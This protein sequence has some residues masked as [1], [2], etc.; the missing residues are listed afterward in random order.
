MPFDTPLSPQEE[1][2]F[3]QWFSKNKQSGAT[4]PQDTGHD[5]DLRGAFKAGVKPGAD[6]HWPD[7]FKKPNHPTFSDESIYSSLTGTKPGHWNG[8]NLI[9]FGAPMPQAPDYMQPNQHSGM[10]YSQQ[11]NPFWKALEGVVNG[12]RG[13]QF[14]SNQRPWGMHEP[15]VM[16]GAGVEQGLRGA[17][18][19]MSDPRN[20]WIG[21]GPLAGMALAGKG[22]RG[23]V[24][25]GIPSMGG[26][27]VPTADMRRAM[28]MPRPNLRQGEVPSGLEQQVRKAYLD[29]VGGSNMISNIL[30]D[31][32][33]PQ[34]QQLTA[35]YR[36][37]NPVEKELL[38][39]TMKGQLH[40]QQEIL[41]AQQGIGG[42]EQAPLGY[43]R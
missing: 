10:G 35:R 42:G 30:T 18:Q 12:L 40:L 4:H 33:H 7:T 24:Q 14:S 16:A 1:Q 26:F 28:D 13:A 32:F 43:G 36:A 11:P 20:A 22:I 37:A 2:A 9:S 15:T 6:T 19:V 31:L 17:D 41:K 23:A 21:M 38:D 8:N 3:Q 27:H 5:Y 25:K 34:N 29:T 39:N